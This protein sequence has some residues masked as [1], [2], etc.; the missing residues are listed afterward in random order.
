MT[1][2]NQQRLEVLTRWIAEILAGGGLVDES[3]RAW[4]LGSS[5]GR[6]VYLSALRRV[7]PTRVWAVSRYFGPEAPAGSPVYSN[8][9]PRDPICC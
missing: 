5:A 6:K 2:R 3:F 4:T 7:A 1:M 8:A 9:R